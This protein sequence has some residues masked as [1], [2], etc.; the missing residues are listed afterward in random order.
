MAGRFELAARLKRIPP[1]LFAEIDRKKKAARAA[2]RDVIDLGVGDPDTP[3][4]D[5]IVEALASA[6]RDPATHRYALDDGDPVF[7]AGIAAWMK[8]RYGVELDPNGE[9]YP[10]IGSKEA[11]A[12]FPLAY[13]NPGDVTLVPEPGYPP[14]E[15]GT[16]LAG[17]EAYPLPLTEENGFLPDLG[18]IPAE[19]LARAKILYLNYPN[20]PTGVLATRAFLEEAVELCRANGIILAQ[21]AAYAEMAFDGRAL[22]ILDIKGASEVAIEFHSL[23][24]TFNMTGWRVGWAAGSRELV[25]GLGK[26]KTNIDSGVFTAV[27]RAGTTALERFDEV[28]DRMTAMYRGRRDVFCEGLTAAGWR[29]R[30]PD[31]TFYVWVRTPVGW[32]SERTAARLLEEVDVITTPGSGFGPSG[33]GYVRAALTVDESRLSEAVE[34]IG[35][36]S[37]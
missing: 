9:I 7:R 11:I 1:Y 4:P 12:H 22:S 16:I 37:W 28:H 15:R 35:K 36:L 10:T 17:G 23:S 33:E 21:D 18:A 6:A 34:R 25:A 5:F 13:V 31:A 26:I 20:S 32:T 24:K 19:T 29:M 14:Y 27:Q 8:R 3:T 30:V 2:G